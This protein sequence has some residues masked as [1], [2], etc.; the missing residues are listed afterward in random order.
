[1][2]SWL[3][4]VQDAWTKSL[5][6]NSSSAVKQIN[7]ASHYPGVNMGEFLPH[8]YLGGNAQIDLYKITPSAM[9]LF[10]YTGDESAAGSEVLP[11][12]HAD[13][14]TSRLAAYPDPT[15]T[16]INHRSKA[17]STFAHNYMT[18][19]SATAAR[20]PGWAQQVSSPGA[21]DV[22]TSGYW[23][24]IG[25]AQSWRQVMNVFPGNS[26]VEIS[27][28]PSVDT[29]LST[30]AYFHTL[31]LVAELDSPGEYVLN[32]STATIYGILPA[33]LSSSSRTRA[34]SIASDGDS[35]VAHISVL[36]S[37][38]NVTGAASN[39]SFRGIDFR[40]ARGSA[41]IVE[42]APGVVMQDSSIQSVGGM[43]LNVTEAPYFRM[44]GG[45]VCDTG[46]GGVALY[47]GDRT[48]L[49]PMS[50]ALSNVAL[51]RYNRISR[52]YAAG[53][54]LG[55]V[56]N[57]VEQSRIF[58]APHMAVYWQG[59]LHVIDGNNM[60]DLVYETRDS[61]AIYSGRDF[62]YS[63]TISNNVISNVNTLI[64][65][66]GSRGGNDVQAVYLDD[67]MS[68]AHVLRNTMV[69]VSVGLLLGGG[70]NNLFVGNKL[71]SVC[72]QLDTA[73]AHGQLR[74]EG[75]VGLGA[76]CGG[77]AIDFDNRGMGWGHA[78][79]HS[80]GTQYDFLSR[81]PYNTSKVWLDTYPLLANLTLDDPCT[82]KYNQ[83]WNN[84]YCNLNGK[85]FID[86][87]GS[88]IAGW[89]S[90]AGNN[91]KQC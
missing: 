32:R 61:G 41:V 3:E 78:G 67:E 22:W 49:T 90:S 8:V 17:A 24:G 68:N 20:L 10:W 64:G 50:G 36:F 7:L 86:Q 9:E 34:S 52:V 13:V 57:R 73:D 44:Q 40:H 18:V 53:V 30:G 76:E 91:V 37:V 21:G 80:G 26:T 77:G 48:T 66:E 82:P 75:V 89:G 55:G 38:V 71:V 59:N 85:P 33:N 2:G 79:C 74:G 11:A 4:P 60:T 69:N 88:T 1:M 51:T 43:G 81:I 15:L 28:T 72:D 12:A 87:S 70:R 25:W 42:G 5:L 14:P 54:N 27:G 65:Q 63:V 46:S 45:M 58:D 62:T 35:V 16:D 39:V 6:P 84:T 19:D 29:H 56:G 83:I 31:N 23:N 47:G